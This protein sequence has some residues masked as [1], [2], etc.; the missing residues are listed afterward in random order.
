MALTYLAIAQPLNAAGAPV[1]LALAGGGERPYIHMGRND[2][3]A[4]LARVPLFAAGIGFDQGGWNGG[5]VPTTGAIE[6][7]STDTA[8]FSYLASLFW[9]DAPWSLYVGD[10]A[11]GEFTLYLKGTIAKHETSG[12]V[13]R[14]TLSDLSGSL[15]Q[16]IASGLFA[17]TGGIEGDEAAASRVKRRTFGRAFNIRGQVLLKA[18]NV[19]EFGDPGRSFREFVAVRDKGRAALPSSVL[20]IAWQGSIAATL[21]ALRAATAPQGGAVTAPSIA[22]VKWWTTPSGPLTADV[23]GEGAGLTVSSLARDIVTAGSTLTISNQALGD[24]LRPGAAGLHVED[25]STSYAQALDRLLLGSSLTWIVRP[26]GEIDLR[27]FTLDNPAQPAPHGTGAVGKP[28]KRTTTGRRWSPSPIIAP[29]IVSQEVARR[30]V[31]RPTKARKLGYQR[32]NTQQSDAEISAAVLSDDVLY[33]NGESATDLQPAQGGADVTAKNQ[34]RMTSGQAVEIVADYLGNPLAGQLPF[35]RSFR[36]YNGAADVSDATSYSL[37]TPSGISA[38]VNDTPGD[39]G[40]GD[41]TVTGISAAE[42]EIV[43]AS[44]YAGSTLYETLTVTTQSGSSTA[45]SNPGAAASTVTSQPNASPG[46]STDDVVVVPAMSVAI[47]SSGRV[48]LSYQLRYSA[49]DQG[50]VYED[51]EAIDSYMATHWQQSATGSGGWTDAAPNAET[52]GTN[53]ATYFAA[54]PP[55]GRKSTV[56]SVSAALTVSGVAPGTMFFRL[57]GRLLPGGVSIVSVTGQATASAA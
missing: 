18:D 11:I 15:T 46:T 45:P 49:G 37:Q 32:N 6:V 21:A 26:T 23:V 20:T 33:P 27:P 43:V 54:T 14:L 1:E 56:G 24:A 25:G 9:P 8:R 13:L 40:R 31:Y 16:P 17:G 44:T 4:G 42:A 29:E 50:S 10:D 28:Y 12:G 34:Q 36:R 22:C 3:R 30:E 52:T 2:W 47:G 19:F 38:T 5:T 48:T 35:T 41:V 55:R 39:V 57:V 7:Y 53:A 51:V